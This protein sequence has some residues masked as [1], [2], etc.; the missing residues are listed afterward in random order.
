MSTDTSQAPPLT[1]VLE[2]HAEGEDGGDDASSESDDRAESEADGDDQRKTRGSES[3]QTD[4]ENDDADMTM[5]MQE[6][7]RKELGPARDDTQGNEP[8]PAEAES[9]DVND[10]EMM[11]SDLS[12]DEA[13]AASLA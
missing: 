7:I 10:E 8:S 9:K 4:D 1:E 12:E 2:T 5:K 11:L 3:G 6:I 13:V